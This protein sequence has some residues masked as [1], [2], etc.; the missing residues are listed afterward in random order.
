MSGLVEGMVERAWL[1]N[2]TG[3]GFY[4]EV[5]GPDGRAFWPLDLPTR[6]HRPPRPP[7]LEPLEAIQAERDLGKRLQ[8]LVASEGRGGRYV[9][10]IL[11]NLLGY[12]SRRLPEI[13]DD[14][15][16]VDDAM[17]WGFNHA[18]GPF[19]TWDALGLDAGLRLASAPGLPG[20]GPAAWVEDLRRAGRAS[21]Y[22]RGP[23]RSYWSVAR[24]APVEPRPSPDLLNLDPSRA[25]AEN[26]GASLL[27]LGDGV[28]ALELHTK[29]NTLDE[30]VVEMIHLAAEK[31]LTDFRALVVV[32]RGGS[33]S[34]GL[35]LTTLP[36][37]IQNGDWAGIDRA[38][39]ALQ[40]ALMALR[41]SPRPVVAAAVG[42][43]LGGGAELAM[44]CDRIVAAAEAYVGQPE[45]GVGLIPAGGG[46]KELLRR[47]VNPVARE[48][49]AD[50]LA[51][52][53][54]TFELIARGKVSGSALE[55]RDWGFLTPADRIV[56][57]PDHLLAAA[58]REAIALAEGDYRAPERGKT[59]YAA[60]RDALAALR[61][62]TYLAREGGYA[63]DYD[64]VL[65][66]H[67]AYVLCG[68]D[69]SEP[70]WVDEQY[71]LNLERAALVELVQQTGSQERIRYF[72]D[73]GKTKRT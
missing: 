30:R 50:P 48:P 69:L 3:I 60:G 7:E 12:S 11:G 35:N 15:K 59:I 4:K 58:K 41:F 45:V 54:R 39:K 71:V 55:A 2:K 18:L 70:Q 1:G 16:S 49:G 9:R 25:I 51:A 37:L 47:V 24:G 42:W 10:A 38:V 17:R 57:N 34:A 36:P 63:T 40:D 26:G 22:D 73:T 29:L 27:D 72:L 23:T 44:A 52:L 14:V 46:C 19:E 66:N 13:A 8:L 43:T 67:V 68:G 65:A 64:A 31:A 53:G 62:Q 56:M 5:R 33:F 21:F 32:G 28:A 61:I 20:T 6:E